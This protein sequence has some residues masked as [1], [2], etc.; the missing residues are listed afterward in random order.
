MRA[1]S[2]EGE[3]PL[4]ILSGDFRWLLRLGGATQSAKS[5]APRA[6]DE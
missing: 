6:K 2:V 1:E 3:A 4:G 5:K